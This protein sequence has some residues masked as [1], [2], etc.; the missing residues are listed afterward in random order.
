MN[1]EQIL[2]VTIWQ[3]PNCLDFIYQFLKKDDF[4]NSKNG[5]M[6]EVLLQNYQSNKPE[7][8]RVKIGMEHGELMSE[9][10]FNF[11]EKDCY[12]AY[13]SKFIKQYAREIIKMKMYQIIEAQAKNLYNDIQKKEGEPEEIIGYYVQVL[14]SLSQKTQYKNSAKEVIDD[15]KKEIEENKNK[16]L[17]GY[18]SGIKRLDELTQGLIPSTI[19]RLVAYTNTGKSCVAYW[20]CVSLLRQKKDGV[21][22]KGLFFSTEIKKTTIANRMLS[23][24]SGT[25]YWDIFKGKSNIDQYFEEFS[26]FDFKIYDNVFNFSEIERISTIEKPDFIVVDFV[27]S[28]QNKGQDDYQRMTQYANDIQSLALNHNIAVLDLSQVSNEGEKNR[29]ESNMIYAKGSGALAASADVIIVLSYLEEEKK[30]EFN[31]KK[32]RSGIKDKFKMGINFATNK[33]FE[34]LDIQEIFT[35]RII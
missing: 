27:Q 23:A 13:S 3:E 5:E 25:A 30:L 7:L 18:N 20:I 24:M 32:N 35:P 26:K 6:Y 19:T 15:L 8:D 33:I 16:P 1:Y 34:N 14:A 28:V 10:L 17:I 21:P 29:K 12:V 9:V 22:L 11:L 31:I 2:L 4:L